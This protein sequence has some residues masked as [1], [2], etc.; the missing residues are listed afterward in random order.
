MKVCHFPLSSGVLMVAFALVCVFATAD[1]QNVQKQPPVS[2]IFDATRDWANDVVGLG[3]LPKL[4][5]TSDFDFGGGNI[6]VNC[7]TVNTP[8]NETIIAVDPAD[9]NHIV[10]GSNDFVVRPDVPTI[11]F[12]V[13]SFYTSTDGGATWFNGHI[14][15]TGFNAT[16]DPGVAFNTKFADVHFVQLGV[17]LGQSPRNSAVGSVEVSTS[18]DGGVT[19]G[20]PVLVA[21]GTGVSNGIVHDKPAIAVDNNPTSP[22][23]GRVYVT[24]TRLLFP[25]P[26]P[27]SLEF[28]IYL[29]YSD[30]G[31]QTFSAPKEISGSGSFCNEASTRCAFDQYSSPVVGHDG[32]VYV[33]FENFD[34]VA[35]NQFLLVRSN[36]GGASF[37]APVQVVP[38][39][40]DAPSDYPTNVFGR[41]TL[42]NSEFRVNSAGNLAMDPSSGPTASSTVL[43]YV[44]SDNRNGTI[45]VGTPVTNTDVFIVK[46]SNGGQTWGA[47]TPVLTG[48]AANND[49]FF[50]WAAVDSTGRLLIRFSDRSYDSANVQYGQTLALSADGGGSFTASRIDTA[51]SDPNDS[52]WSSIGTNGKSTFIGDYDGLAVGSDG[53]AHPIWTDMRNAAFPNPP[54]G[55]GHRTED[56]VT[57]RVP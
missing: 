53:V 33:A 27:G 14:P 18:H 50:P 38:T 12:L 34:T 30:D 10:A 35:E 19:W 29:A 6:R 7:D 4:T 21:K 41:S 32:A 43:Y 54:P 15:T 51:L 46:S 48:A 17:N 45:H 31:A 37:S 47:V 20:K 56:A 9:A 49:Q 8:H 3:L 2:G 16:G 25:G 40:F 55:R 5:C 36:D 24:W 39:V 11:G 28:P 1:A 22:H 42:T 44:F 52:R 13:S 57:V 23:Y 26:P